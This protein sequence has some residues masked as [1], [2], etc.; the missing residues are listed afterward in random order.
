MSS[1]STA[2]SPS[3]RDYGSDVFAAA[4]AALLERAALTWSTRAWTNGTSRTGIDP[5]T[6]DNASSTAT[7]AATNAPMRAQNPERAGPAYRAED[8]R[9]L[10]SDVAPRERR[11]CDRHSDQHVRRGGEKCSGGA[12]L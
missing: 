3:P 6:A 4:A 12:D 9:A 10:R 2:L 1:K 5:N 8:T 7:P 11:R